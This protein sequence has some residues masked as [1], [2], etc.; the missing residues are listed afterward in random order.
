M[1]HDKNEK[2]K[3]RRTAVGKIA[4][5]ASA[6]NALAVLWDIKSIACYE[7]KVDSALVTPGTQKQGTYFAR[8]HFAGLPWSGTFT[9]ELNHH[10]FYSEMKRG[11]FG[12]KVQGG[13]V[14][15]S[16][17]LDK[18]L[19]THYERYEFPYWL[20]PLS[21]I[22][23]LYL[24]RAMKKELSN[25]AQLIQQTVRPCLTE[26]VKLYKRLTH[27]ERLLLQRAGRRQPENTERD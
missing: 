9:Y 25:L 5:E 10:G 17:S 2:L 15:T 14:V 24:H 12:V 16:E 21:L 18:C 13:F 4:V 7:P 20:A 27:I 6:E 8:G 26:G 22:V 3:L 23:R 11:A 19:I 1:L